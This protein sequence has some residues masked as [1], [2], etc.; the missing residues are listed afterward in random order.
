MFSTKMISSK[1]KNMKEIETNTDKKA[2]KAWK[3]T[4]LQAKNSL[5][6]KKNKIAQLWLKDD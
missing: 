2:E 1:K 5:L 6:C 3:P 4:H